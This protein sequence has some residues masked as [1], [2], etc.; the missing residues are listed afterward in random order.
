MMIKET[1][2]FFLLKAIKTLFI[3]EQNIYN[4]D[5][6]KY[7]QL[8]FYFSLS[9]SLA[10]NVY[11]LLVCQ[12]TNFFHLNLIEK[13]KKV[14]KLI[15]CITKK[16]SRKNEQKI[17]SDFIYIFCLCCCFCLLCWCYSLPFVFVNIVANSNMKTVHFT[18][19]I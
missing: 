6:Y 3:K 14:E 11:N 19:Y 4:L 10:I 17:S 9:F 15:Y 18:C 2:C 5:I 12:Q 1:N 7:L 8:L 16:K 13:K